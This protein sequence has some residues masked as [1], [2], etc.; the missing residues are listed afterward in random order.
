M[1]TK[2]APGK[3]DCYANAAPDEPMFVL[4]G[5]DPAA[6]F[7][8]RMWAYVRGK[9]GG[10]EQEKLDEAMTCAES[11]RSYATSRGKST[12]VHDAREAVSNVFEDSLGVIVGARDRWPTP[13][14]YRPSVEGSRFIRLVKHLLGE[15]ADLIPPTTSDHYLDLAM[16]EV[17]RLR[18]LVKM[19]GPL[20][21]EALAFDDLVR[22][23]IWTERDATPGYRLN[24]AKQEISNLR[25]RVENFAGETLQLKDDELP[26]DLDSVALDK[27]D[28][29]S[30]LALAEAMRT[31]IRIARKQHKDLLHQ[32][33]AVGNAL[34]VPAGNEHSWR[35]DVMPKRVEDC[36]TAIGDLRA[37]AT[38][39]IEARDKKI[40]EARVEGVAAGKATEHSVMTEAVAS[41]LLQRDTAQE[42]ERTTLQKA[43]DVLANVLGRDR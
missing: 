28:R 40:I 33:N 23:T 21:E 10:T 15:K 35:I 31:G 7:I 13:A 27:L 9:I 6:S 43:F 16:Q 12:K 32:F 4:L 1:G 30:L 34:E 26:P 37:A 3:F 17:D 20:S 24:L 38:V 29:E 19:G 11:M 22:H 39:S 2:N 5:R 18:A 41:A 14:S 8:V 36:L 42:R 25:N